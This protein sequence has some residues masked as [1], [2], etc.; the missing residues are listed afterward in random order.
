MRNWAKMIVA[1]EHRVEKNDLVEFVG[2]WRMAHEEN[3]TDKEMFVLS[4]RFVRESTI[5]TYVMR[6][7]NLEC[8]GNSME[9]WTS[10]MKVHEFYSYFYEDHQENIKEL[11][12]NIEKEIKEYKQLAGWKSTNYLIL[13]STSEKFQRSIHK[14]LKKY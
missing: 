3:P 7:E 5:G 9:N 14:I 6:L 2:L 13:K 11:K 12:E 8:L 10:L 4:D 1:K